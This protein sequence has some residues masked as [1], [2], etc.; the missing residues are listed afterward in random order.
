VR[1]TADPNEAGLFRFE[2]RPPA[3]EGS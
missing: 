2:P 1:V 3:A